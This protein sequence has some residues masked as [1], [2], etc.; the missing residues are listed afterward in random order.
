MEEATH[1]FDE[2]QG[3]I[4]NLVHLYVDGAFSRR[5][6]IQRVAG[7]TGSIAA[8]MAVLAEFSEVRA[9]DTTPACPVDASVPADAPDI[10]ASDIQFPGDAGPIFAHLA[11]P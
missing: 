3:P 9:D 5:E 6:L 10:N 2:S 4:E 11:F 7:Y 8:S 1:M